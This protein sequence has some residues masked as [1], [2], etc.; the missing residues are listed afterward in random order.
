MKEIKLTDE[1]KEKLHNEVE[2]RNKRI[3]SEIEDTSYP[4]RNK[5]I[6]LSGQTFGDLYVDNF[7]GRI[8]DHNDPKKRSVIY[9][10]CT[11]KCGNKPIVSGYLLRN[12]NVKSCGCRSIKSATKH[13][14]SHDK[15]YRK[16]YKCLAHMIDRCYNKNDKEYKSYGDRGIKI[17]DEWLI[18]ENYKGLHNFIEWAYNNGYEPGLTIDRIDVDGNYCPENCRWISKDDQAMNRT[19]N[20]F[21]QIDR[22]V[23]PMKIWCDIVGLKIQAVANRINQYGWDPVDAIL[24]EKLPPRSVYEPGKNRRPILEIPPEYE[25]YNKYDEWVRKGKI[26]PVEETIYKDCPYIEH[27]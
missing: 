14:Y 9:Y 26:K 10:Q 27:K 8:I 6:D 11:C 12:G 7:I 18:K 3:L 21:I 4:T 13:G 15:R 22:W 23:F 16:L 19:D 25:K 20:H 17:C 1:Q 2:E 5:F 24:I